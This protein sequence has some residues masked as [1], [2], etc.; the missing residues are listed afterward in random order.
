[1]NENETSQL[2]FYIET[3]CPKQH[4][5]IFIYLTFTIVDI[6]IKNGEIQMLSTEGLIYEHWFFEF[7]QE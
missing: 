6:I 3:H 1:M 4:F 5:Y 2:N 7:S